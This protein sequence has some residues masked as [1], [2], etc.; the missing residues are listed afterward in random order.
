VAK[1][2]RGQSVSPAKLA[3]DLPRRLAQLT[4]LAAGRAKCARSARSEA[5][6]WQE[7]LAAAGRRL[8][9]AMTAGEAPD[10]LD[11]AMLAWCMAWQAHGDD[12]LSHLS[13]DELSGVA[14]FLV[15]EVP[16]GAD[17]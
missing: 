3:P 8:D 6:R 13:D 5:L 10:R 15:R 14:A 4:A 9:V 12:A 16:A 17:Q 11:A 1:S 7:T 2:G